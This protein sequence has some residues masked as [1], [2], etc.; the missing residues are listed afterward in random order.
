MF[1]ENSELEETIMEIYFEIE[2]Y[3]LL[4]KVE[5]FTREVVKKVLSYLIGIHSNMG[6]DEHLNM[7]PLGRESCEG[8]LYDPCLRPTP[9]TVD[10]R[11]LSY[12]Y[13]LEYR[14]ICR[15]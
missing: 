3:F 11:T 10:T 13:Y 9:T 2:I 12:S 8:M 4:S 14:T 15:E 7:L 6:A 5:V 1:S